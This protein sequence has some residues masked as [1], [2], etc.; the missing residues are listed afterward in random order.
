MVS[1]DY[2][3][4]DNQVAGLRALAAL[5]GTSADATPL[6]RADILRTLST[7]IDNPVSELNVVRLSLQVVENIA[8]NQAQRFS[9]THS[10]LRG[11]I[12]QCLRL[13]VRHSFLTVFELNLILKTVWT[14]S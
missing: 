7:S 2:S 3:N 4:V 5:T 9:I 6:V 10:I 12:I 8:K 1:S 13:A 14:I 11:S